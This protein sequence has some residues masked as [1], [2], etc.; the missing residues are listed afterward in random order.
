MESRAYIELVELQT[1]IRDR[2]GSLDRWV[3][4]EIASHSE[5]RGHH[6]LDLIQKSSAGDELARARGIIWKSNSGIITLFSSLTGQQLVAGISVVVRISVQY[7]PRYGLSLVIQDID[8]TYSIGQ[9]ELQK[10]ETVRRL[11]ESGLINLQKS[12]GLPFLPA[13]IAVISSGDAAGY[14]DFIKHLAGNQ[15]GF[16]YDLTL[17]QSLMQGDRC[18]D[19]I[20]AGI[21]L[22]CRTGDF[23][24]ILILRG[25]GAESDLFC[26]DDYDLGKKIAECPLPVLTAVGHERD[27]HIV[28]MV[29]NCHFKT[30]TALA[31]FIV[32]W[33]AGAEEQVIDL[34]ASIQ[35]AV[36]ERL[37]AEER[38]LGRIFAGIRYSLSDRTNALE[39]V[40]KKTFASLTGQMA[41]KVMDAETMAGRLLTGIAHASALAADRSDRTVREYLVRITTGAT[42]AVV[43]SES[44]VNRCLTNILFALNATVSAL[45]GQ[46]ALADASI[47]ASDPRNILRQGYVLAMDKDGTV[48]KNVSSRSVGDSFALKFIDGMWDC[49]VNGIK[50]DAPGKNAGGPEDDG[51]YVRDS[52]SIGS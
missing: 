18:P 16:R 5:V 2:I 48:L 33:T 37:V 46:V 19:S 9:R 20:C 15:Y 41:L 3:R 28:D 43:S 30:P 49:L 7:S 52:R 25:G 50:A 36:G 13:R 21:D 14:G 27:Y 42:T 44:E 45:E 51:V 12:I 22:I 26:Y 1:V 31:D 34:L 4:V 23:D 24:L 47:R 8:A 39:S 38:S 11:T 35:D 32:D 6:Y 29:A 10:Q 17:F 40:L